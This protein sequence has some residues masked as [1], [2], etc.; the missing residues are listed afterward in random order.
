MVLNYIVKY[1]K[2]MKR[3]I[4]MIAGL[5]GLSLISAEGNACV[6]LNETSVVQ[7]TK[8]ETL[9]EKFQSL[10]KKENY[11]FSAEKIKT[12]LSILEL[13]QEGNAS[14]LLA[15]PAEKLAF[16][17]CIQQLSKVENNKMDQGSLNWIK[18][19]N[20]SATAINIVWSIQEQEPIV[21]LANTTLNE[22]KTEIMVVFQN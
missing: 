12:T 20:K 10:V 21:D 14:F 6:T 5:I 8:V 3:Q 15:K 2:T 18:E 9:T 16:N 7:P 17:T 22:D 11:N 19:I 1:N 4:I 13:Y